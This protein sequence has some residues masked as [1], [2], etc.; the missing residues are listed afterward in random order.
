MLNIQ[1][2]LKD[3]VKQNDIGLQFSQQRRD[4]QPGVL[5]LPQAGLRPFSVGNS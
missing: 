5:L 3:D 2:G 1:E 4:S